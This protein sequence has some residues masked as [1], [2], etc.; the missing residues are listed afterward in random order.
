[1]LCMERQE[2]S[3]DYTGGGDLDVDLVATHTEKETEKKEEKGRRS[4]R[5]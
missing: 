2:T 1:M 5:H 3:D 4:R